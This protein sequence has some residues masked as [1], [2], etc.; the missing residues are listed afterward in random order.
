M[1]KVQSDRLYVSTFSIQRNFIIYGDI[2]AVTKYTNF[3][4]FGLVF[5]D[6]YFF[7]AYFKIIYLRVIL[8][9]RSQTLGVLYLTHEWKKTKY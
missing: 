6:F 7:Y 1:M 2:D 5:D 8:E 3:I 9:I 4:W